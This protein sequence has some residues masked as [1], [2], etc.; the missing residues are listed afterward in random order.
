[1]SLASPLSIDFVALSSLFPS[2]LP[3]PP[4]RACHQAAAV[5]RHLGTA[6][7][8]KA[9]RATRLLV[10]CDHPSPLA[11]RQ[12][13]REDWVRV[14]APPYML[15]QAATAITSPCSRHGLRQALRNRL[16]NTVHHPPRASGD[17]TAGVSNS[18]EPLADALLCR[19]AVVVVV[20]SVPILS[21]FPLCL[22]AR[23]RTASPPSVPFNG[24][25]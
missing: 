1:M 8:G 10:R 16:G 20:P 14:P 21:T 3:R 24:P 5:P 15:R 4:S 25:G 19:R 6:R 13:A 18:G 12:D 7:Q 2:V 9:T 23:G 22:W 17:D 11:N